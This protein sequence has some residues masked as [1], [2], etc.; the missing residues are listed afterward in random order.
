VDVA[1]EMSK[2]AAQTSG[3]RPV[4]MKNRASE[5][6]AAQNHLIFDLIKSAI[7]CYILLKDLNFRSTLRVFPFDPCE[8]M[9]M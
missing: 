9:T 5:W 3:S 2:Q 6:R 1:A 8:V 4:D 7:C